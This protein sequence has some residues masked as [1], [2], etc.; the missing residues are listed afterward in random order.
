ML[1]VTYQSLREYGAY[2]PKEYE[3]HLRVFE[4]C[5]NLRSFSVIRSP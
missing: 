2:S 4:V 3:D 5:L 1:G